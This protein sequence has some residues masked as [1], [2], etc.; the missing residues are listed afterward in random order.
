MAFL[1][2]VERMNTQMLVSVER[3]ENWR[4]VEFELYRVVFKWFSGTFVSAQK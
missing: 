3:N 4:E 2:S 1:G